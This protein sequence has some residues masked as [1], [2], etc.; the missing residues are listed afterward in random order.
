[1]LEQ[2]LVACTFVQ[3]QMIGGQSMIIPWQVHDM[4]LVRR[5]KTTKGALLGSTKQLFRFMR[6]VS[7]NAEQSPP[8][9]TAQLEK[10]CRVI[11]TWILQKCAQVVIALGTFCES[12]T[13][14]N[15]NVFLT[16]LT[17]I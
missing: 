8:P 10:I 11:Q 1:M 12:Q 17:V 6:T 3:L 16:L 9:I 5:P 2:A 4:Q 15:P 13:T 14:F 7:M